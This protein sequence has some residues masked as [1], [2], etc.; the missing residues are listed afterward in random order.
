MGSQELVLLEGG[1]GEND[2]LNYN[3]DV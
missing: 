1:V 3:K 2:T